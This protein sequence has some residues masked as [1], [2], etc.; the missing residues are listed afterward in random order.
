[1]LTIGTDAWVQVVNDDARPVGVPSDTSKAQRGKE[2]AN[3][4]AQRAVCE[5]PR[6]L[7][8]LARHIEDLTW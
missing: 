4:V 7:D 3:K 6:G 8:E 2:K 1:M 5:Q